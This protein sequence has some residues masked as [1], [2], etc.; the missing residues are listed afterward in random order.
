LDT[1]TARQELARA[2]TSDVRRRQSLRQLG[3]C[4]GVGSTTA[5]AWSRRRP[6]HGQASLAERALAALRVGIWATGM[7]IDEIRIGVPGL[8]PS[9]AAGRP[10][11][12]WT[13]PL[14]AVAR[15]VG[16]TAHC[17][18]APDITNLRML[19]KQLPDLVCEARSVSMSHLSRELGTSRQRLH[20]LRE[21]V[22]ADLAL[23]EDLAEWA[24][25]P[26]HIELRPPWGG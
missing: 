6:W 22:Q 4:A 15:T 19:I 9:V 17:E 20:Q 21:R 24:G 12:R 11:Q 14:Q 26:I 2:L 13:V 23:G 1:R 3:E 18:L 8:S 16:L 10:I 5:R 25:A 7:T